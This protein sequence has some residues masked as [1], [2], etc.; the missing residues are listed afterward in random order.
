MKIFGV[1]IAMM[2]V[3]VG[4]K[5]QEAE[6]EGGS[7]L[8]Y[9]LGIATNDI[10][11]GGNCTGLSFMGGADFSAGGFSAGAAAIT[12]IGKDD[13]VELDWY[14]SYSV[15]GA[16]VMLTDY[17]WTQDKFEYFGPYK[18]YHYLELGVGYDFSEKT[19]LPLSIGYN[20]MLAGANRKADDSQA[21]SSYIEICYAPSLE[22]GLDLGFTVGAAIENEEALMY[23]RKDG[24]NFAE[25]KFEMSKT[26]N[27]K[28]FCTVTPSA[29]VIC[30]PTGLGTHGEAYF[31]GSVSFAF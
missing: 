18:T 8:T 23:T 21:H 30:N 28:D 29:A 14:A 5:A 31:V 6:G 17:S 27:L 12:A 4:A 13:Y 7:P 15:G 9:N 22:C 20:L 1:L 24:F 2:M 3:A 11:R 26:Y 25:L 10:W 19:D 16:Y